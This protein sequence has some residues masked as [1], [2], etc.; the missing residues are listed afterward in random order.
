MNAASRLLILSSLVAVLAGCGGGNTEVAVVAPAPQFIAWQGNT[1]GTQVID[2]LGRTFAFYADT[3]CLYNAQT[4]K[5][6]L[7][8]CL[9][10]GSNVVTYGPFRG[11]IQNVIA[12]DGKCWSAIVD[13]TTGYFADI[14]LDAYGREVVASTTLLPAYC[15]RTY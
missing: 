13:Q 12:S 10:P 7:A 15:G 6:N 2:G 11:Q 3:G 14:R 1:G 4:G 9:V 8:F 5:E